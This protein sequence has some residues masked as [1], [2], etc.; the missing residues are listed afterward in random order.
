MVTNNTRHNQEQWELN[1]RMKWSCK[2]SN[3]YTYRQHVDNSK[4]QKTAWFPHECRDHSMIIKPTIS[5]QSLLSK[6]QQFFKIQK[7]VAFGG[8]KT[9]WGIVLTSSTIISTK[10]GDAGG[11]VGGGGYNFFLIPALVVVVEGVV[12]F[13]FNQLPATLYLCCKLTTRFTR[14]SVHLGLHRDNVHVHGTA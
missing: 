8:Q 14:Y 9:Y 4:R 2:F 7:C 12:T 10:A 13:S 11:G 3:S 6:H 1:E 5:S